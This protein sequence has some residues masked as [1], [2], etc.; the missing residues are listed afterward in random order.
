M[1]EKLA[2]TKLAQVAFVVKDIDV[3]SA[4]WAALLGVEVPPIMTTAPGL[5]VSQKVD[6]QPSDAQAKLAFF[7]LGGVQLELIEPL[8]GESSWQKILD[9]K[10]EGFHH[11]AFWTENMKEAADTLETYEGPLWHI[12]NMGE[13]GQFAYFKTQESLGATIELLENKRTAV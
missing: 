10:G 8:G 6:G 9:E 3:A 7:D 2:N 1:S 11:L 13:E 5:T 4:K 12:G